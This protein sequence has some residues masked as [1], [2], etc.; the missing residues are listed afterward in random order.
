M[1]SSTCFTIYLRRNSYDLPTAE[2]RAI[3]AA[4]LGPIAVRAVSDGPGWFRPT[5]QRHPR[6]ILRRRLG[7]G[8]PTGRVREAGVQRDGQG[9][10]AGHLHSCGVPQRPAA[11]QLP[12]PVVLYSPLLELYR[13]RHFVVLYV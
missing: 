13:P 4:G 1:L 5:T 7:G 2:R 8:W 9:G 3:L 11:G 10:A 6:R 12:L